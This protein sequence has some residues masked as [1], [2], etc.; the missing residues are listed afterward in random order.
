MLEPDAS[1][2]LD[3]KALKRKLLSSRPLHDCFRHFDALLIGC[4]TVRE[5]FPRSHRPRVASLYRRDWS[6]AVRDSALHGETPVGT[7]REGHAVGLIN[8]VVQHR[9]GLVILSDDRAAPKEWQRCAPED[10]Y[11]SVILSSGTLCGPPARPTSD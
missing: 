10:L 11:S 5:S 9:E 3:R 8:T 1:V 7:N 2:H 4:V 6:S